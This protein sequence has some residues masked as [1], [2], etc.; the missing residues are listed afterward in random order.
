M[1]FDQCAKCQQC[2]HIEPGYPPL[3]ITLSSVE[4]ERWHSI[5]IKT[6][7]THL[8]PQGCEFGDDKPFSCQLYPLSYNPVRQTFYYDTDCPLMPDYISQ[9]SDTE[10][11]ASVHLEKMKKMIKVLH[12]QDANFLKLNHAI[13]VD[14]FD[15]KRLPKSSKK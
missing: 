3:E 12:Q 7:C 9:L 11:E 14:Y 13:D 5:C 6:Q 1:L 2:C 15:L 10:S 8:G 4:Q